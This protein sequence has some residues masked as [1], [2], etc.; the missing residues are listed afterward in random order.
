[1]V[2]LDTC[3][4]INLVATGQ[5]EDILASMARSV[6]CAAVQKES[7]YLRSNDPAVSR[8]PVSL[9]ALIAAGLLQPVD[10]TEGPE[11]EL[12]VQHASRLDDGEA[13]SLAIA[14]S[15]GFHLATD[16]RKGRRLFMEAVGDRSR[17]LSTAGI[18]REWAECRNVSKHKLREAIIA[19]VNR[20]KFT[21]AEADP[22]YK[23]WQA[24]RTP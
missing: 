13:M 18:L 17:L 1:V 12:Y 7:L 14:Q 19:V 23:W 2:V 9:D 22:D 11:E 8:E 3:V 6:V 16:D 4:L 24:A 5:V 15:R 10:V 21:P 20:A